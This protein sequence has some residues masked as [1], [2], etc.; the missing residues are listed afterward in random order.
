MEKPISEKIVGVVSDHDTHNFEPRPNITGGT[1]KKL[2]GKFGWSTRQW[3]FFLLFFAVFVLVLA[4]VSEKNLGNSLLWLTGI[5]VLFYTVETQGL[6][7]EMVRQNEISVQPLVI[8]T[9]AE[10][11]TRRIAPVSAD[12]IILRNIGRG[13]ALYVKVEDVLLTREL[14]GDEYVS[15]F[16]TIDFIE[17]GCEVV[18]MP[19]VLSSGKE[20]TDI[21]P[22]LHFKPRESGGQTYYVT[23]RYEDVDGTKRQSIIQ[24]GAGGIKLIRH[25]RI[26]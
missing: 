26:G 1:T 11:E 12:V 9:V 2:L 15:T 7:L 22:V 13:P 23:I 17:P 19:M 21:N 25:G 16:G 6:R 20:V 14:S 5:V 24:M 18:A 8:A 4:L 3:V 10:R